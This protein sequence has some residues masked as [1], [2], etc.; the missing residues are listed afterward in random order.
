MEKNKVESCAIGISPGLEK[1]GLDFVESLSHTSAYLISV[2][3]NLFSIRSIDIEGLTS[4]TLQTTDILACFYADV[5][6]FSAYVPYLS[7]K[8]ERGHSLLFPVSMST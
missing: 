8:A 4:S 3:S 1:H 5:L 6:S 7:I 2:K